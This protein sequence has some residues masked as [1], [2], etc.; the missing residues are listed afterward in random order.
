MRCGRRRSTLGASFEPDLPTLVVVDPD[1][2]E[3][4]PL[5]ATAWSIVEGREYNDV[6]N[7][8]AEN[9]ESDQGSEAEA[10]ECGAEV[11]RLIDLV[12]CDPEYLELR[13]RDL[14]RQQQQTMPENRSPT[15]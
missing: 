7:D 11:S 6:K 1:C 10:G 13:A 12:I 8:D 2:V 3:R 5:G 14:R 4:R 15:V 9:N